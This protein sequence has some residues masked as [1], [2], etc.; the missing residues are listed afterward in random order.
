MTTNLTNHTNP[1]THSATTSLVTAIARG[2]TKITKIAKD[3]KARLRRA[4]NPMQHR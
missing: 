2:D 1:Q 4:A 3:T